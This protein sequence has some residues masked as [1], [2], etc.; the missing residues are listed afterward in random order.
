VRIAR[1]N[2]GTAIVSG[3]RHA[4]RSI[5]DK[6]PKEP[7]GGVAG[8]GSVASRQRPVPAIADSGQTPAV[9]P[10]RVRPSARRSAR[11]SSIASASS[12]DGSRPACRQ[13]LSLPIGKGCSDAGGR[14]IALCQQLHFESPPRTK[15][16]VQWAPGPIQPLMNASSWELVLREGKRA[17][18]RRDYAESITSGRRLSREKLPRDR[19]SA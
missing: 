9:S 5:V 15:Q 11:N 18:L 4:R 1:R 14:R 7:F 16:V 3:A 2:A 6:R 8:T 13:E 19:H 17:V 10:V 12:S